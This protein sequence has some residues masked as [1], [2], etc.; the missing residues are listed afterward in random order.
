VNWHG[1]Q[2]NTALKTNFCHTQQQH[3]FHAPTPSAATILSHIYITIKQQHQWMIDQ[4]PSYQHAAAQIT[5][6]VQPS[7]VQAQCRQHQK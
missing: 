2:R 5:A 1:L 6:F 3:T 7:F 4:H